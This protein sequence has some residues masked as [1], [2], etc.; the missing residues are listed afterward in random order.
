[1]EFSKLGLPKRFEPVYNKLLIH[2]LLTGVSCYERHEHYNIDVHMDN[3]IVITKFLP[4][5]KSRINVYRDNLLFQTCLM[6]TGA[7]PH[8]HESY[9]LYLKRYWPKTMIIEQEVKSIRNGK[10]QEHKH[11]NELGIL[12]EHYFYDVKMHR[13][14]GE[15]L[16]KNGNEPYSHLFIHNNNHCS[17]SLAKI[18]HKGGPWFKKHK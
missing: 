4:S 2:Y 16:E 17:L 18:I 1:M 7:N 13:K 15:Y 12:I 3:N 9:C 10:Y 8:G 5:G 6:P 11:Y 14:E